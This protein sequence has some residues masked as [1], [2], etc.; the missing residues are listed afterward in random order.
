[1]ILTTKVKSVSCLALLFLISLQACA[2]GAKQE[3]PAAA[4][5]TP[6]AGCIDPRGMTI[7]TRFSAPAGYA[8]NEA[9]AGTFA[10]YLQCLPLKP[11]GALVKLFDGRVKPNPG[12]YVAVVDL[13][14]GPVEA[15]QYGRRDLH[16][17]ADALIRLRAEF[18]FNQGRHD[19]I[20]FGFT[21]GFPA[22]YSRWRR[23]ERISV[24]NNAAV[25]V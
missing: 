3:E 18:L 2:Q 24:R 21:S 25:W 7:Q 9:P 19:D 4:G 20:R 22:E 23:G 10:A 1:M 17:C 6:A 15:G 11:H 12:V 13:P 5:V 8:R 14:I 16:Q